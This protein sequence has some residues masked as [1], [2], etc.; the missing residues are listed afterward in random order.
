MFMDW[1]LTGVTSGTI[2]GLVQGHVTAAKY[3]KICT[4]VRKAVKPTFVNFQQERQIE[5]SFYTFMRN[6]LTG[7]VGS[8]FMTQSKVT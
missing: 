4:F 2:Q 7:L 3:V 8:P 6:S 5:M 1:N